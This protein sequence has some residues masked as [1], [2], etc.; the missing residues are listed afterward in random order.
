MSNLLS[1]A[2]TAETAENTDASQFCD[3][4]AVCAILD[5]NRVIFV[6]AA[7]GTFGYF[8]DKRLVD[9]W[10]PFLAFLNKDDTK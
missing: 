5:K 9:G 6:F 1:I 2:N 10:T 8:H 7:K 3:L 4:A